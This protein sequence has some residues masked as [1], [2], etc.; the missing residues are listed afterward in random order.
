MCMPQIT[1]RLVTLNVRGGKLQREA[2]QHIT[3][4]KPRTA[5]FPE[6]EMRGFSELHQGG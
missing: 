5:T 3:D 1:T 6:S 4:T 2:V